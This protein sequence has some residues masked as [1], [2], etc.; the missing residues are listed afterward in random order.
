MSV[1]VLYLSYKNLQS[2]FFKI[3]HPSMLNVFFSLPQI[4][5][6]TSSKQIHFSPVLICSHCTV[7]NLTGNI[8]SLPG[9]GGDDVEYPHPFGA[10]GFVTLSDLHEVRNLVS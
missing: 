2:D 8:W 4:I 6:L 7:I 1:S 9:M 10:T 5:K 3:S